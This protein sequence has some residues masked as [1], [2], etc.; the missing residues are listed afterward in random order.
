[1]NKT[2]ILSSPESSDVGLIFFRLRLDG[3]TGQ[4]T[5]AESVALG[6]DDGHLSLWIE[7]R[8]VPIILPAN[9]TSP[10]IATILA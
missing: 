10:V 4:S 6:R 5:T 9:S 8:V 3:G 1:M 2:V 7:I